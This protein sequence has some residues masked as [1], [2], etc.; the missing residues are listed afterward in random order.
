MGLYMHILGSS[1]SNLATQVS[2]VTTMA[3]LSC[4]FA[5]ECRRGDGTRDINKA[6]KQL[7]WLIDL[8]VCQ[9]SRGC[10]AVQG[11]CYQQ[12]YYSL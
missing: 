5:A 3:C 11:T 6:V 12:V 8:L 4:L 2:P 7:K 10:A 1:I 9:A